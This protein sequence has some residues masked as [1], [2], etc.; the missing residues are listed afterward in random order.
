MYTDISVD[1]LEEEY[2]VEQIFNIKNKNKC[3]LQLFFVDLKRQDIDNDVYIIYHLNLKVIIEILVKS[4]VAL[5]NAIIFNVTVTFKI[6][7]TTSLDVSNVVLTI[8]LK[9]IQ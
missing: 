1:L 7:A 4:I 3:G 9:I 5:Q 8:T 2:L 6:I